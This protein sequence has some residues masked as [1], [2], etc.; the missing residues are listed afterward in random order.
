MTVFAVSQ[1]EEVN[2]TFVEE[3]VPSLVSL[4]VNSIVTFAVGW[5]VRTGQWHKHAHRMLAMGVLG[6]AG[7]L[8]WQTFDFP[9]AQLGIGAAAI[10]RFWMACLFVLGMIIVYAPGSITQPSVDSEASS[11][12]AARS[13]SA[14][15]LPLHNR[16]STLVAVLVVYLI[17][18]PYAG[19]YASSMTFLIVTS[20]LLG[21][22][23]VWVLLTLGVG[24][25]AMAYFAFQRALYVPLPIG[26][27]FEGS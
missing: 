9:P 16:L 2:T 17:L 4:D 10:P 20:W 3:T 1:S 27:W 8:C 12:P 18:I 6:F 19:Y 22:R 13:A 14:K 21:E 25:L 24:W 7:L 15:P 26:K 11:A 23:R 5:L